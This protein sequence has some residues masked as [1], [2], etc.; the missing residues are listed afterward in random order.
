MR[1]I[2][3]GG[4]YRNEAATRRLCYS[5]SGRGGRARP[6]QIRKSRACRDDKGAEVGSSSRFDLAPARTTRSSRA[7][8]TDQALR[9]AEVDAAALVVVVSA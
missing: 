7:V 2:K 9:A 6:A 1:C 4:C 3:C 8:A 5:P